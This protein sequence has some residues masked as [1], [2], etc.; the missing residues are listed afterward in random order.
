MNFMVNALAFYYG[1][2]LILRGEYGL[3]R[4]F[5]VFMSI[6]FGSMSA[7]RA[8]AFAPDIGK[9]KDAARL[10]LGVL[11]RKPVIHVDDPSGVKQEQTKGAIRV[12]DVVFRY[13]TRPNI[14]VLKSISL[15]A[16]P[17]ETIALV[18]HSGSG[19]STIISLLERF[20]DPEKGTITLDG[21]SIKDW[22]LAALRA[23]IALVGQEPQLYSGTIRENIA[24]G[25]PDDPSYPPLTQD[26]IEAA[27]KDANIHTFILSLP[28]GYDT[29]LGAKGAQLSG[30]Q[31][32][33]IAIARALVRKP[34]VLLLDEATSALDGESEKIVQAALDQAS[35][36][37]TTIAVAHRL[38]TIQN[39]N[40]IYVFEDGRIVE[41]G[42]H[43]ILLSQ[44]GLYKSMVDAQNLK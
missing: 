23:E 24:F 10:I 39:A 22:N 36:N 11:D 30:G 15:E 32:Q 2:K 26:A 20:Y 17:G 12:Q 9:A 18:G 41:S 29:P 13:P 35:R 3:D 16:Q 42:T 33:R 21:V 43:D 28:Q 38:A 31:K 40:H 1:G 27:A 25:Y 4:L 37:T 34:K 19:K 5:T 7:G 8:F 44:G 6:I 14:T